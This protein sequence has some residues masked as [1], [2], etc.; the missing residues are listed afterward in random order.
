MNDWASGRK[1]L[2]S[3]RDG[4]HPFLVS[5]GAGGAR[6]GREK[7]GEIY[8]YFHMSNMGNGSFTH[9]FQWFDLSKDLER[10]CFV[11]FVVNITVFW[12]TYLPLYQFLRK[13]RKREKKKH[14]F[15]ATKMF[16]K[17]LIS[18][19]LT[20]PIPVCC[21][22]PGVEYKEVEHRSPTTGLDRWLSDLE[23]RVP[24]V[25]RNQTSLRIFV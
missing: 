22:Q 19:I 4:P 1:L 5:W 7:T 25:L 2:S 3:D 9:I 14:Y 20:I 11:T 12:Y 15:Y 21:S 23:K 6:R 8:L 10:F 18:S 17:H 24:R 16:W 13:K